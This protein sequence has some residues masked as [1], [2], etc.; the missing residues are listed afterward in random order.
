MTETGQAAAYPNDSSLMANNKGGVGMALFPLGQVL[1]TPGALELLET[2]QL[3]PLSFIQRHVSGDWGD[4]CA[5][6]RQV[7]AD[8]LQYGYRLMSVYAITPSD[9]LWIITEADRS[10]TTL[11]LP[12][13]Y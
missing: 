4:I 9:K 10:S 1:A 6:D 12:E 7:N 8:A 2:H 5:E 11:L 3:P 13:E